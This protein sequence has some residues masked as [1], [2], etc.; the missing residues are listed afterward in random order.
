MNDLTWLSSIILGTIGSL[1]A[2]LL[3]IWGLLSLRPK[4][5]IS[6]VIART[7]G[8]KQELEYDIKIVNKTRTSIINLQAKF[9]LIN[10][11][12]VPGGG[13]IGEHRL[14]PLKFDRV[15]R[16]EKFDVNT[17]HDEEYA[18]R[19][20]TNENIEE[21]WEDRDQ[22]HLEFHIVATHEFSGLSRV[23]KKKYTAGSVQEGDFPKGPSIECMKV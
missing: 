4:I 23:F 9:Y 11:F 20:V 5:E 7:K 12:N 13:S 6:N 10:R 21:I 18:W 19:F 1:V 14:I 2:S 15:L 8:L 16:L 3:W 22:H 17:Y